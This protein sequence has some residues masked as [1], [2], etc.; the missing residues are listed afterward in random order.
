[1]ALKY[2]YYESD[3]EIDYIKD[4]KEFNKCINTIG[5][6][7]LSLVFTDFIVASIVIYVY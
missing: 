3:E 6:L 5:K 1:M 4:E 7:F 2:I